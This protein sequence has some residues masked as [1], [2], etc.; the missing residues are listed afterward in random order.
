M[1]GH[2]NDPPIEQKRATAVRNLINALRLLEIERSRARFYIEEA[3][4][5][6]IPD[7]RIAQ[8]CGLGR[9]RFIRWAKTLP[10]MHET[11]QTT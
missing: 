2:E 5:L 1:T 4:D 9:G 11:A 8:V 3:R 6:G 10:P 7:T